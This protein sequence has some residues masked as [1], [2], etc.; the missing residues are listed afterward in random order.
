ML[1]LLDLL[2]MPDPQFYSFFRNTDAWHLQLYDIEQ[3]LSALEMIERDA[4]SGVVPRLQSNAYFQ[5]RSI[6]SFIDD[7]HVPFLRREVPILH[8]I[9]VPFPDEWHKRDDDWRAVDLV[10]VENLSRV[11]RVFVI[12]YLNIEME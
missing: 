10:T 8:L 6:N 11:L 3:R 12:E 5:Q 4:H 2:G 7:D 9:P 1:V